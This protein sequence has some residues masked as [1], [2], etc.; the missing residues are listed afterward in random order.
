MS[1]L[2]SKLQEKKRQEELRYDKIAREM[3]K[4]H[5][6]PKYIA[7]RERQDEVSKIIRENLQRFELYASRVR[8]LTNSPIKI[9]PASDYSFFKMRNEKDGKELYV[10]RDR[11]WRKLEI[12]YT[13]RDSTEKKYIPLNGLNE[14]EMGK[15]MGWVTGET[16]KRFNQIFHRIFVIF[17]ILIIVGI[18]TYVLLTSK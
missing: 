8:D 3:A 11:K 18:I 9:E 7:E 12:N 2:L 4:K 14:M 10:H 6:D 5:S 16:Q 17:L 13:H 1:D 15:L